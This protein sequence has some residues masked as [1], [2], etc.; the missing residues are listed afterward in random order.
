MT[1]TTNSRLS[2][3]YNG[4]TTII[5]AGFTMTSRYLN[6]LLARMV[7]EKIITP[8]AQTLVQIIFS[9]KHTEDNPFPSR[10]E[11][12]RTLNK[13]VKAIG[14]A[15]KAVTDSGI[16]AIKK[17]GRKNTYDFTPLFNLLEKYIIE[18]VEKKNYKVKIADLMKV[19]VVRKKKSTTDFDE[20]KKKASEKELVPTEVEEEVEEKQKPEVVLPEEIN[21][22][23]QAYGIDEVGKETIVQAYSAYGEKL[24]VKVF[25]D[26][27]IASAMKKE[28]NNYFM[29]C[30]T[31]AF[32]NDEQ[33]QEAPVQQKQK[34]GYAPNGKKIVRKEVKPE[35][36][37]EEKKKEKKKPAGFDEEIASATTV[38]QLAYIEE[39]IYGIL[40]LAPDNKSAL[41]L[42]ELILNKKSDI[43]GY[44]VTELTGKDGAVN[45]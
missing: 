17:V 9:Y 11:L 14:N 35:W 29:T 39:H 12:G 43:L 41:H 45:E 6:P 32:K 3:V 31:N 5:E 18:Y 24:D 37:D 13:S 7:D 26:K 30:I 21:A 4:N 16:L 10:E 33:P 36:L 28:F 23:I 42:K 44:K 34:E 19:K 22:V 20:V 40:N 38:E 1:D 27:I 25:I 15:L 2:M 8:S